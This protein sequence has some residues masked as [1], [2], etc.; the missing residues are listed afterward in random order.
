MQFK[1]LIA[2]INESLFVKITKSLNL[3]MKEV[4]FINKLSS[5]SQR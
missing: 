3:S 2:T 5:M 4:D 1:I